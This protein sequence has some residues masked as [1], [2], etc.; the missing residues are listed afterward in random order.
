MLRID[1]DYL[2][3]GVGMTRPERI[4]GPRPQYTAEAIKG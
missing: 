1:D 4:A 3:F 2:P